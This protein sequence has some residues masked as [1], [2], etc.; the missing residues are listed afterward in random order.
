V[1]THAAHVIKAF[2]NMYGIK[3]VEDPVTPA[4]RRVLFYA[5]DDA[6]AKSQFRAVAEEFGFA[7]LDLGLLQMGR[8]MQLNGP[9][10]GFHAVREEVAHPMGIMT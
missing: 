2:D 9:L 3:I 1:P 8:L 10:T 6:D 7:P 4:G 5:G